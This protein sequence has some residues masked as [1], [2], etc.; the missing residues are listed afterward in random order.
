[1]RSFTV[2]SVVI[3]IITLAFASDVDASGRR[4]RRSYCPVNECCQPTQ[5][6]MALPPRGVCSCSGAISCAISCSGGCFSFKIQTKCVCQCSTDAVFYNMGP[7]EKLKD[8][9][10]DNAILSDLDRIFSAV[11]DHGVTLPDPS[12]VCTTAITGEKTIK[13][14]FDILKAL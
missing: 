11:R 7:G 1:M 8:F 12:K 3:G 9:K 4:H 10:C 2:L 14:I 5:T 6:C 13:E